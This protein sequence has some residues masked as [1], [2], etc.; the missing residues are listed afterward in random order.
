M[1]NKLYILILF[2]LIVA[3]MTVGYSNFATELRVD[4]SAE[5]TGEWNVAI[6]KVEVISVSPGCEAGTPTFTN[7][8]VTF[9]AKLS[10]PGDKVT[11]QVTIENLGTIDAKLQQVIFT[12]QLD[13]SEALNY[14][15]TEIATELNAKDKST[16]LITVDYYDTV[17]EPPTNTSKTLTGIIDYVQK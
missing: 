5:I 13:G 2:L 12:E 10:K 16:F 9:D 3:L 15:T 1:R 7:T 4:G 11:Y 14:T 6:T 8:Q 17:T